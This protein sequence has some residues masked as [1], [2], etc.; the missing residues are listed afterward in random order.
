MGDKEDQTVSG[1]Y[2]PSLLESTECCNVTSSDTMNGAGPLVQL[3]QGP[4]QPGRSNTRMSAW[5]VNPM[6]CQ[7][8]DGQGDGKESHQKIVSHKS[9][10]SVEEAT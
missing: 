6:N 7:T 2:Y 3:L 5:I 1:H 4:S 9:Y 8:R 10:I